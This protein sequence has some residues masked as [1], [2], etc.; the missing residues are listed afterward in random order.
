MIARVV[1]GA[2]AI[3][4]AVL[5]GFALPAIEAAPDRLSVARALIAEGRAEEAVS[6]MQDPAW[7]GVAEYR[8]GR[9]RRALAA[10]GEDRS[11][12]GF[13]NMGNA[14]ARLHDWDAARKS[15]LGALDLDPGHVD[16]RR[17]LEII[18]SAEEA[19]RREIEAERQTTGEGGGGGQMQ[20]D[21]SREGVDPS[22][23]I[24]AG[25]VAGGEAKPAS[26]TRGTPG[27][28]DGP[29]R[30]GDERG[31]RNNR[32]AGPAR[33]RATEDDGQEI[34]GAGGAAVWL[35]SGQ[36]AEI[37]LGRIEDDPRAALAAR[38]RA[39]HKRRAALR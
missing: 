15:Y 2:A 6:L 30:L 35:E 14:F 21:R 19:E 37:L 22:E 17:N 26:T 29:G 34:V 36:D 39:A 5:A 1:L 7:R 33:A 12:E 24:R 16:A 31:D 4:L 13:Y 20:R 10:F 32:Q 8:A 27:A 38:L 3:G 18:A 23:K 9:Y 28:S 11:I 25:D